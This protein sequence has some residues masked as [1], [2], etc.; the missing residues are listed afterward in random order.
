MQQAAH[1][2]RRALGSRDLRGASKQTFKF[3]IANRYFADP[4]FAFHNRH[5]L[6]VAR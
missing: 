2:Q 1:L 5:L 4:A 6:F 3:A